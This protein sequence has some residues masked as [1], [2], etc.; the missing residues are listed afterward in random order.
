MFLKQVPLLFFLV[1][2]ILSCESDKTF[3][4]D[5][6]QQDVDFNFVEFDVELFQL[7]TTN[8]EE[9]VK[10]LQDKYPSF[11]NLFL[12][13]ILPLKDRN[14]KLDIASLKGFI[15]DSSLQNLNDTLSLIIN[16]SSLKSEFEEA[17]KYLKFYFPSWDTPN[18]YTLISGF[19]YQRFILEDDGKDAIGVGLDFFLGENYP[20]KKIDPKNPS[21]SS[22]Q[23][24]SFNKDHIVKKALEVWL[25]DKIP[26]ASS[27][28]LVSHMI[29]NGKKLYC[30]D[31]LLPET[32][33]TVI[34]EYTA[35][36]LSWAEANQLQIWSFFFD[37]KLFYETNLR[38]LNKYINPS[39]DSPGM[40]EQAPGRIA[41]YMGWQ[42]VE[43]YMKRYPEKSLEML[44][45]ER[46]AQ[47]IMDLSKYKP[48]KQ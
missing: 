25:E 42:I 12:E 15:S 33:D 2:L 26:T 47:K 5:I 23:T 4:P 45:M 9:G 1:F 34:I 39:P 11:T 44:L 38:K 40:P 13:S 21:F 6:S 8:I 20:Y 35:D 18:V 28:N 22:Y 14:G 19:A 27:N 48:K 24:R 37:Q 3:I 41:N 10:N 16:K 46:D 32:S 36:Q 30:L 7:D 43:A 29:T 31:K 17:F